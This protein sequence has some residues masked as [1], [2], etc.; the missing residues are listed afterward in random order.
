MRV[1]AIVVNYR[2]PERAL[3]AVQSLVPG[4]EGLGSVVVVEN[5]SQDDSFAKLE[6]GLRQRGLQEKVQLVASPKNGGFGYGNNVA[7]RRAYE[8]KSAPEFFYLLNPDAIAEPSTVARLVE[9]LDRSPRCGIAGTRIHGPDGVQ[10]ASAFRFPNPLG[11]LQSGLRLGIA[12]RALSRW[13]VVPELPA[14]TVLVDWVSGASVMVRR[15]VFDTI[16]LFDETFF[17]YFEE[18]DLCLRS[19]R[20]GFQ[21]W[22]VHEA[23]VQHEGAVSTGMDTHG[24][25]R[26]R[27]WFESRKRF[28][29]KNYGTPTLVAA[30]ALFASG[31]ALWRVRRR[32]QG[33]PDND[34]PHLLADFLR[35][36]LMAST[37]RRG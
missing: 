34:P 37:D 17:L 28:F 6:R 2:T 27:Y 20:A 9:F 33:K 5:D 32:L 29:Q 36:N 7:I 12:T 11:D 18:T 30:N 15:E 26:P 16:G 10:H 8:A 31:Y 19:V 35:Y 14:K 25:R 1:L 4:L 21:T 3:D 24:K 22:Y 13:A 23:C